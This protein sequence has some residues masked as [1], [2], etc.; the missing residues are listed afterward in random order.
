MQRAGLEWLHRIIENPSRYWKRYI[1]E[2]AIF[3]PLVVAQ[4]FKVALQKRTPRP[5]F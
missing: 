4:W 2:D 1:V 5:A 3:F